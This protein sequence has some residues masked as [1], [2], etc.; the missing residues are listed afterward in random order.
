MVSLV[1]AVI[2][3][4]LAVTKIPTFFNIIMGMFKGYYSLWGF[5]LALICAILAI[6]PSLL[7]A[8][9]LF[10]LMRCEKSGK[11]ETAYLGIICAAVLNIALAGLRLLIL[12]FGFYSRA[13]YAPRMNL[14]PLGWAALGSVATVG[15]LYL[16][17]SIFD[18]PPFVG[19]S[20]DE[21]SVMFKNVPVVLSEA[22]SAI[23]KRSSKDAGAK[24]RARQQYAGANADMGQQQYANANMGQ[25]QYTNA[26][27][28]MGQQQYANA[29]ANM[30][31]QYSNANAYMGSQQYAGVPPY[32]PDV[33]TNK[34][35]ILYI[36]L[37]LVTCGIY[38]LYF[39]YTMARDINIVCKGDGKETAGLLKLIVFTF[40]TCGMYNYVWECMFQERLLANAQ[41]FGVTIDE[42]GETVMLW[43]MP[44][45]L[46]CGVG[47]LVATHILIKNMNKLARAYNEQKN[48]GYAAMGR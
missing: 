48:A 24:N 47:P 26:N 43:N 20:K 8:V 34:S 21:L 40:L 19:R 4:I 3:V 14:A 22:F 30:G 46:L 6:L 41:R 45:A 18:F 28:N 9:A 5:L 33:P 12:Y 16:V 25:Q 27:A 17:F 11:A 29:N 36:V 39:L 38:S 42:T 10:A 1:F 32:G 23:G 35:L 7:M 15:I 44:G 2:F 13:Y 37:S 31:Q